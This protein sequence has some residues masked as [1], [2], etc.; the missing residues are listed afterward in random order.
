[1]GI[2][3]RKSMSL[4]SYIIPDNDRITPSFEDE[5]LHTDKEFLEDRRNFTQLLEFLEQ[6]NIQKD[7]KY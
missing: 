4:T 1:V 5:D 3:N 2:T 7:E 6:R